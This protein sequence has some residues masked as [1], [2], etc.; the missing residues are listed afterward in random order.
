MDTYHFAT[1]KFLIKFKECAF[2]FIYFYLFL[3]EV[4]IYLCLLKQTKK[5]MKL[6]V[7][8]AINH[9]IKLH[10]FQFIF[11]LSSN[12]VK[13]NEKFNPSHLESIFDSSF[14]LGPV[15]SNE[16]FLAM[17][18]L[19]VVIVVAICAILLAHCSTLDPCCFLNLSSCLGDF[20]RTLARF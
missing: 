2:L 10:E 11:H 5:I 12:N 13:C 20:P 16:S 9:K 14:Q 1:I 8:R 18:E 15:T 6:D 3:R 4:G 17:P 7:F 19:V